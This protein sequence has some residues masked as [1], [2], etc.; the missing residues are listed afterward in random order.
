MEYGNML[1]RSRSPTF[2][3]ALSC[4]DYLFKVVVVGN[5]ATGKSCLL[6]RFADGKFDTSQMPTIGVDFVSAPR[7]AS[8]SMC[9]FKRLMIC[10]F[11]LSHRKSRTS[12]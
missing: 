4:S 5:A 3:L 8:Q 7:T 12:G 11:L 10:V 2:V 9:D 1:S 6:Q